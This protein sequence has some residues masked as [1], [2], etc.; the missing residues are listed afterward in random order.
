MR[1]ALK[2]RRV[3]MDPWASA[4]GFI[5]YVVLDLQSSSYVFAERVKKKKKKKRSAALYLGH[6][7]ETAA[8]SDHF[9]RWPSPNVSS[10][11]SNHGLRLTEPFD[12]Q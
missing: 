3:C 9:Q 11:V 10:D 12:N 6:R 8:V 2:A 7:D 5:V 4:N 1:W